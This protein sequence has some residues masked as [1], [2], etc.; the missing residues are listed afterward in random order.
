MSGD[1]VDGRLEGFAQNPNFLG[2]L[3]VLPFV[4]AV[5]LA[6]R[7]RSAWLVP[8]TVCLAAMVATQS[9]G[10]FVSAAAGVAVALLQG[11]RRGIQAAIMAAAIALGTVFPGA[12][13]AVEHLAVGDR[14]AAELTQNS[15]IREHVAWFAAKV[16]VAHP[17]RGIGYGVFPSYAENSPGLGI[18]I[19]THNDYLRL[20]AETGIPA[21]LVFLMLIWLGMKGPASGEAAVQRA[22]VAAYAVG[23]LFANQL[24]NLVVSTPFWLA[25][26][27]LL[28][29]PASPEHHIT[30]AKECRH[31]R[32]PAGGP[33][34]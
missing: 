6:G 3:L 10:A 14:P 34:R 20:A 15:S 25:L 18:Y 16:A 30:S 2:A 26:G 27:C 19:A 8:A 24:A 7:R 21:F 5:G 28:A 12:I 32:R 13:D 33:R 31:D 22:V 9:R 11:R 4:A 29:A 1:H 17:L 23:M